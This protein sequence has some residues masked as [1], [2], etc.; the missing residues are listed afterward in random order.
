MQM[1]LMTFTSVSIG[2]VGVPIGWHFNIHTAMQKF[3]DELNKFY[4]S[5]SAVV[6]SHVEIR[7]QLYKIMKI[8]DKLVV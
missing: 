6:N 8:K 3:V 7:V 2:S 1:L 4:V 5:V